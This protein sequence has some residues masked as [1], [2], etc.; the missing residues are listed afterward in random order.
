MRVELEYDEQ[1]WQF[2]VEP[3]TEIEKC[4]LDFLATRPIVQVSVLIT[5]LGLFKREDKNDLPPHD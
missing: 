1:G 2:A 5:R 4:A 3:E